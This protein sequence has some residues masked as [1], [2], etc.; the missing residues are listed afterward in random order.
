[1]VLGPGERATLTFP[2]GDGFT[3]RASRQYRMS[4]RADKGAFPYYEDRK[5]SDRR[6][7]GVFFTPEVIGR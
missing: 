4:I 1:V 2:V 3:I 5:S 7:I 6:W